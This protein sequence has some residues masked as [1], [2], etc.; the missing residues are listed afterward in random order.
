MLCPVL[1]DKIRGREVIWISRG[2][3]IPLGAVGK[4]TS[5]CEDCTFELGM[6]RNQGGCGCNGVP[7]D[8]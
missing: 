3:Y 2:Q 8:H 7:L 5:H 4:I 1:E 6:W